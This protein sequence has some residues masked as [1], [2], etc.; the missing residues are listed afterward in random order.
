MKLK[1]AELDYSAEKAR[2][3]KSSR[4]TIKLAKEINKRT[5]EAAAQQKAIAKLTTANATLDTKLSATRKELDERITVSESTN[6][7]NHLHLSEAQQKYRETCDENDRRAAEMTRLHNQEVE[8]LRRQ[9]SA[10]NRD[11]D[12]LRG[13]LVSLE[14]KEAER[15]A[16]HTVYT[17][18][19][20]TE[21]RKRNVKKQKKSIAIGAIVVSFR[22]I[23]YVAC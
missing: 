11:L 17:G 10:S 4:S 9:L 13:K 3:K 7:E 16:E 19:D 8:N 14:V 12:L 1:Q 6:R 21:A 22:Q 20:P 2:R 23:Y 5:V 15:I 18:I